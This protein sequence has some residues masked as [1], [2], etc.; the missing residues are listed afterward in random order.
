MP[1]WRCRL[2]PPGTTY[3]EGVDGTSCQ[4]E[5]FLAVRPVFYWIL[6][7]FNAFLMHF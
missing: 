7:D 4:D 6:M 2:T 3:C 1:L 5:A